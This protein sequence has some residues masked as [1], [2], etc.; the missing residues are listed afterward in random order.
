MNWEEASAEFVTQATAYLNDLRTQ[1]IAAGA[2]ANNLIVSVPDTTDL[3]VQLSA[4]RGPR[5]ALLFFE[6]SPVRPTVGDMQ[7]RIQLTL[8]VNGSVVATTF[9]PDAPQAFT[10][11]AALDLAI[12]KLAESAGLKPELLA[13]LRTGLSL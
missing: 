12:A 10:D 4:S 1:L 3:T 9:V 13:K 6:L 5:N 2:N 8:T 7:V 11:P